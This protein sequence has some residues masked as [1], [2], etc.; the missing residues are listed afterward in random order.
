V[1][2]LVQRFPEVSN[3][4]FQASILIT[5]WASTYRD[6]GVDNARNLERA[7][8]HFRKSAELNRATIESY[9]NKYSHHGLSHCPTRIAGELLARPI[10]T[11][12]KPTRMRCWNKE[13][14]RA[15]QRDID[16]FP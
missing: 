4:L 13:A 8:H 10:V 16:R 2:D 6:L 12:W 1:E 3:H 11:R 9:P 15:A 14:V 5:A 7:I